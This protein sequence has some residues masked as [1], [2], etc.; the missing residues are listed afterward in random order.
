MSAAANELGQ[1][2]LGEYLEMMRR[3]SRARR[4]PRGGA[5]RE[6]VRS[7]GVSTNGAGGTYRREADA[8]LEMIK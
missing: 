7:P 2:I 5:V 6:K 1:R 8:G 4:L 3:A